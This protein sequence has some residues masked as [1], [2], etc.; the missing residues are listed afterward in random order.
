MEEEPLPPPQFKP[1]DYRIWAKQM[2]YH[3]QGLSLA[4]PI[5]KTSDNWQLLTPS[6]R[7]EL[8]EKAWT[9]I[10]WALGPTYSYM[11]AEVAERDP[12]LL[13][14]HIR[15]IY[16]VQAADVEA[17]LAAK[18]L[19]F[20]WEATDS[21]EKFVGRMLLLQYDHCLAG[22]RLTDK[23]AIAYL[24]VK[25]PLEFSPVIRVLEANPEMPL[26]EARRLLLDFENE[27]SVQNGDVMVVDE[28]MP[29]ATR[30]E[31]HIAR[32]KERLYKGRRKNLPS[33]E[34]PVRCQ[35]CGEDG[36]RRVECR[37][38]K[39][40][41]RMGVSPKEPE[42]PGSPIAKIHEGKWILSSAVTSHMTK[43][44]DFLHERSA[45]SCKIKTGKRG[46]VIH[47]EYVGKAQFQVVPPKETKL[48]SFV[49]EECSFQPR[50]QNKYHLSSNP[51]LRGM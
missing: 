19:A 51:R 28:V 47:G 22:C 8:N 41:R 20:R 2:E 13:W 12:Q 15:K 4:G 50:N 14:E 45:T 34:S 46:E 23:T 26:R 25:L 9:H 5:D 49:S 35:Y 11:E 18:L 48:W 24:I 37:L 43:M 39:E 7:A 32:R 33:V 1:D 38:A 44:N 40:S 30:S 36:H 21:V 16:E 27:L 29:P 42:P 31:D 10:H 3:L 17:D 6:Q